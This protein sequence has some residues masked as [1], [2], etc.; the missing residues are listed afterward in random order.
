[1]SVPIFEAYIVNARVQVRQHQT[2]PNI[3]TCDRVTERNANQSILYSSKFDNSVDDP[4]NKQHMTLQQVFAVS[5]AACPADSQACSS[6]NHS[7]NFSSVFQPIAR[8]ASL[9]VDRMA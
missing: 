9:K 5:W 3:W 8:L 6:Y 4:D 1:M 7:T 2:P